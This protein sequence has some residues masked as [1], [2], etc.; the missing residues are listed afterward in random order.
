MMAR[1]TFVAA[2][3]IIDE[4]S[5]VKDGTEWVASPC[6]LAQIDTDGFSADIVVDHFSEIRQNLLKRLTRDQV[7]P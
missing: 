1:L 2:R 3:T 6:L 5:R 4:D 7:V